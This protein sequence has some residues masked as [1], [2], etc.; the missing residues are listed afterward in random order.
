LWRT[1]VV[2]VFVEAVGRDV[3]MECGKEKPEIKDGGP[4]WRD[5]GWAGRWV[6]KDEQEPAFS[7]IIEKEKC[8][9]RREPGKETVPTC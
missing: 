6:W 7:D 2:E 1:E 9:S 8:E 4:G 5:G 3:G